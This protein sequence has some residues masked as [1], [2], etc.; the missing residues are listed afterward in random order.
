ML[1]THLFL[2][3]FFL[4]WAANCIF[5]HAVGRGFLDRAEEIRRNPPAEVVEDQRADESTIARGMLLMIANLP[6]FIGLGFILQ[7]EDPG[8]GPLYW[9]LVVL[10][11]VY[12]PFFVTICLYFLL[13]PPG[14]GNRLPGT[15]WDEE[16]LEDDVDEHDGRTGRDG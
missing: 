2:G 8:T 7:G 13:H 11:S 12:I 4:L 14:A 16:I 10:G 3:S 5:C 6:L 9:S 1:K 15:S